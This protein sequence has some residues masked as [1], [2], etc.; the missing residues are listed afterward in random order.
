MGSLWGAACG[1]RP[2]C[3]GEPVRQA[4]WESLDE[5]DAAD[6]PIIEWHGGGPE[7]WSQR[8]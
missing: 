8:E 1:V 5:I 4:G 3:S 7:V 2:A 6:L